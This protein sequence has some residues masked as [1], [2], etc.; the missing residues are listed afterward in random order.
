MKNKDVIIGLILM[1]IA[2]AAWGASYYFPETAI[3]SGGAE[4]RP[5]QANAGTWPRVVGIALFVLSFLLILANKFF[6]YLLVPVQEK[7]LAEDVAAKEKVEDN[8]ASRRHAMYFLAVFLL[9]L[10]LIVPLGFPLSTLLFGAACILCLDMGK[11]SVGK[12]L[13]WSTG[14]S[15]IIIVLF[16]RILYLPLPRGM[17]IFRDLTLMVIF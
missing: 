3:W 9:Y 4:D 16:C 5:Y 11:M 8:Q 10:V 15:C 14:V 7:Q 6:P 17:G 13:M 12:G 2:A 1:V